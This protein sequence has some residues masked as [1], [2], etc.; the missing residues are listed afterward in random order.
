MRDNL[1]EAQRDKPWIFRTYAGHSTAARIRTRSTARTSPRGRPASRSPSICRPR[2]ATTPTTCWRTARSARSAC[3]SA[4]SATCAR[5]STASRSRT[6]NTSMT[7]NA[8]AAWL[9][10]LYIAVADEQGAPRAALHRHDPERHH[11]GISL[12]RH[13]RVPAGA[14]DAADQGRGD[15]HHDRAA[16]VESDERLLLS[17]AGSRRDAGAGAGLRA[18]HRHRRARH[19]EGLRRGDAG[20]VRRGGRA[21][22]V[23]RQ[24]RPALRHRNLQDARLRRAVGRDHARALRHHRS[25]SSGCSATACR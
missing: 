3:R 19:G 14:V 2:P 8:T 1:A 12:A 23:L 18:R 4:I 9:M 16:E 20:E 24:C 11:Q 22:L 21:H 15:L 13:L 10:A 5:C 25:R 6:M 7:I 17:S